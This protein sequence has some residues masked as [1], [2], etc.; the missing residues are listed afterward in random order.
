MKKLKEKRVILRRVA[1]R[2]RFELIEPHDLELYYKRYNYC[3]IGDLRH[4]LFGEYVYVHTSF[5]D[6]A[7]PKG[8]AIISPYK[9][10]SRALREESYIRDLNKFIKDKE[11]A[12]IVDFSSNIN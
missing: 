12:T 3:R 9:S 2:Y 5:V 8:S 11:L 7:Y 6:A 4:H 10:I 1:N